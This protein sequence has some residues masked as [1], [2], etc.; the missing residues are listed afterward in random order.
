[1][2]QPIRSQHATLSVRTLYVNQ[3]TNMT[4]KLQC[5]SMITKGKMYQPDPWVVGTESQDHKTVGF[6]LDGI[7]THRIRRKGQLHRVIVSS[8]V[9]VASVDHLEHVSVKMN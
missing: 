3:F 7:T 2:L 6:N 8:R 1:M 5:I 9:F 4:M